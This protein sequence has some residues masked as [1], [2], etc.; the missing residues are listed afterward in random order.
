MTQKAAIAAALLRGEVLTIM[1][2]FKRFGCTNIPREVSRSIED[3]FEVEVSRVRKDII[4]TWGQPACYY[5]YRLNFSD[6]NLP[7]IAKMKEYVKQ[8]LS[9][10]AL[11]K[12]KAEEMVYKQ[13]SMWLESI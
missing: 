11:P 12:T 6:H 4:S 7:G 13:T 3:D 10:R 5:E 9:T 2:G 8:E 1:D